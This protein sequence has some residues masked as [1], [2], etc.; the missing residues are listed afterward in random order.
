MQHPSPSA[1][2]V[3]ILR[4]TYFIYLF[5]YCNVEQRVFCGFPITRPPGVE[6]VKVN[7]LRWGQDPNSEIN[8]HLQRDMIL[9]F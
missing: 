3:L 8:V 9:Q 6:S 4:R 1:Q 7:V 5:V 2:T